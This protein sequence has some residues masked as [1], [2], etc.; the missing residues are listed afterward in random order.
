M[1]TAFTRWV[2]TCATALLLSA[3]ALPVFDAGRSETVLPLNWAWFEGAKVE[4]V[5][6]DV[7][8]PAMAQA[9][10]VNYVPRLADAIVGPGQKSLLE[11]VYMFPAGTQI[12]VFQSVPRPTGAKNTDAGYS[13]LWRV[14]GVQWLKPAAQRELRS[15]EDILRA[16][17]LGEVTLDVTQVVVNC[18][19]TRSVDRQPLRG[20]R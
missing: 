10:G 5:T 4:Y 6:T 8:D 18:P 15:E 1:T 20:V 14:V 19:I 9:M 3:C 11:R 17:D 7:S 16:V 2:A 13:P 12:N